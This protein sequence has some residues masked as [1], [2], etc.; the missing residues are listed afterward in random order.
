MSAPTA[1]VVGVGAELGLGAALCRRF[2]VEGYH[3]LVAG[4]S[5]AKLEQIARGIEQK[6]GHATAA[7]IDTT[8]EDDVARLFDLAMTV[9]ADREPADL[10][11]YNAGNNRRIDFRE[12]PAATFEDF[13]RVGCFGG[14]LVGRE[15][16]RRLVALGRGSVI[17][18]GASASLR[19]KPGFAL[20][21]AAKAGLRAIAQSMAREYG[22]LG[23]HVAHVVIDGG[24]DGDRLR[25]ARPGIADERGADGLLGIDAIAEMYWQIHRQPRSAW[26]Q[27]IDLR[28]F[29]ESF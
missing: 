21:A 20:F 5:V 27:E 24:I 11:V 13:W 2:A 4:R 12:L 19:G 17:F 9:D 29:K 28:P 26:T 16:A 23:V 6:G 18:T 10:V 15:A 3:V 14:F 8:R 7:P 25:G 22:L 1:V